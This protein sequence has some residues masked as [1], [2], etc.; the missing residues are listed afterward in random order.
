MRVAVFAIGVKIWRNL[1]FQDK[2]KPNL[3]VKMICAC[4]FDVNLHKSKA[5]MC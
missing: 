5:L 3:A 1:T 2:N 4:L